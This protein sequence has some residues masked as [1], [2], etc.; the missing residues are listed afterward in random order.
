[1]FQTTLVARRL[2]KVGEWASKFLLGMRDLLSNLQ[3]HV[4]LD[5]IPES[6]N[7]TLQSIHVTIYVPLQK[8]GISREV[9]VGDTPTQL[10]VN[11]CFSAYCGKP[12][13]H[14]TALQLFMVVRLYNLY[15]EHPPS[16]STCMYSLGNLHLNILPLIQI[17]TC[18][19]ISQE[20]KKKH[21][22]FTASN[23]LLFTVLPQD[24]Q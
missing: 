19:Y 16:P 2:V 10:Q 23:A 18:M 5:N 12:L 3:V 13:P 1:M 9:T 11:V 22:M 6:W 7:L 20:T 21:K 8:M 14:N 24:Y 4:H 17:Y 15:S